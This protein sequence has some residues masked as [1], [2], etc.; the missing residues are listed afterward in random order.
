MWTQSPLPLQSEAK[1]P[2]TTPDPRAK[3]NRQSQASLISQAPADSQ[4]HEQ[5]KDLFH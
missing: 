5:R 3:Y 2:Q 4:M 1:L